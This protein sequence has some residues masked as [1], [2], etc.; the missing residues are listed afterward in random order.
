MPDVKPIP[1]GYTSVTPYLYIKG[2]AQAIDFYKAAFGATEI[3]R[4]P[5]PDGRLGHAEIKIGNAHVMLADE[6]PEMGATSPATLSGTSVGLLIY[7]QDVDAAAQRA[8]AAGAKVLRPVK[9]Q[10]YGDRTGTFQDPFGHTWTLATHKEDLSMQE[11]QSR[12]AAAHA[13]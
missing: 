1:E 9:D 10:F 5:M 13:G 3:F 4:W 6:F 2:A 12:A 7:V 8:T 11:M